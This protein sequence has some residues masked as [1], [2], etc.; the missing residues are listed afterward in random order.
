MQKKYILSLLVLLLA[1]S[2]GIFAFYTMQDKETN[3]NKNSTDTTNKEDTESWSQN[4]V[5]DA[6]KKIDELRKRY[7]VKWII[8]EGE[9]YLNNDLYALALR[10]FLEAAKENP[11]D[12]YITTK[13]AE[14]YF[15]MHK[16]TLAYKYYN[17]IAWNLPADDKEKKAL[18]LIYQTNFTKSWSVDSISWEVKEMWLSED[19][20]F[21]YLTS[22]SCLNNFHECKKI[23]WDKF[24][25]EDVKQE[26]APKEEINTSSGSEVVEVTKI[27]SKNL[28]SIK[29]AIESYAN[30]QS[31]DISYKDAL[32]LWAFVQNK[33]YPV[34]IELGKRLLEEKSD[35]KPVLKIIA[36]A[37]F[38][39]GN[40][41]SAKTYLEKF[42]ELDQEDKSGYYFMGVIQY[43]MRE[44]ILSN[45][46][47]N[48]ALELGYEPKINIKR[49]MI[50][51][52]FELEQTDKML[53]ELRSLIYD[54]K[55]YTEKDLY[56]SIYYHIIYEKID[57][58]LE[59]AE[60]WLK[61]FK[62]NWEIYGYIGLI[63]KE[64]GD[65][66]IAEEKLKKWLE[67][68]TQS[69]FILL[70]LGQLYVAKWEKQKSIIYFKKAIKNDKW[71]EFGKQATL[72]LE[73][74]M[75]STWSTNTGTTLK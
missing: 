4:A 40:Y 57:I 14:S 46:F 54:E 27:E 63:Y 56:L 18:S 38:E 65:L 42:I 1:F 6:Q 19:E 17:S 58:A 45:I 39:M 53:S 70:N 12:S 75:S 29:N 71:W 30:F 10:K 47:L 66:V 16:Y 22:L 15:E 62:D 13:I 31:E 51:N 41:T 73:A 61:K 59:V 52:Y 33:L 28:E 35:Y 69:P 44:F 25:A 8:L 23:F 32:I 68:S 3:E 43:H 2:W 20:T 67:L 37:Y 21:Y 48:K 50:Y 36:Q 26:D 55:E 7:A 9:N 24:S 5:S 60:Y 72:E 74:V 49:R 64:K 34:A 11:N